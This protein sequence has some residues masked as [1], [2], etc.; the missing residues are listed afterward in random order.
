MLHF[1]HLV[2]ETAFLF[3]LLPRVFLALFPFEC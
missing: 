2:I 1:L 3:E